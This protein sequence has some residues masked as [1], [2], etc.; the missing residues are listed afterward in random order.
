M[1]PSPVVQQK[2]SADTSRTRLEWLGEKVTGK[3]SGTIRLESGWLTWKDNK[4]E[5]GEFDIDM[6]SIRDE[7]GN[8]RLEGHLR[9][10]DFFNVEKFPVARLV[11]TGSTPFDKGTGI[12]KGILTI[13]GI[14]NPVEFKAASQAKD[15]G[16]WFYSNITVDRTK[17]N[18]RYGSG[19]FF[20]N[21]GDKTIFDEF[22]LKVSL[23]VKSQEG[24]N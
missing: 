7:D 5:S 10:D 15:G 13:R 19:S 9:S 12:V 4:I 22:T 16:L 8:K 21:L 3:H 6:A 20:D 2:F 24:A 1:F 23:Y 11:L 18:I 17:Y 14:S